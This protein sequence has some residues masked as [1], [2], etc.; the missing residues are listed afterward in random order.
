MTDL[1]EDSL[2]YSWDLNW[3]PS[4]YKSGALN[5]TNLPYYHNVVILTESQF[6]RV[7]RCVLKWKTY[8]AVLVTVHTSLVARGATVFYNVEATLKLLVP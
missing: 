2:C 3:T 6:Q 1:N 7:A 8:F 4:R 5:Y